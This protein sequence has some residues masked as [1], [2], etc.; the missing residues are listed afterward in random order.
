[1][2]DTAVFRRAAQQ[3]QAIYHICPNMHPDEVTFGHNANAAA[4]TAGVARFVYHSVLRPQSEKMPHHWPKL[5]VEEAL[6]ESGLAVT[7]LQPAAYMQ[8]IAGSWPTIQTEGVYRIPYPVETQLSWVDLADVAET[9]VTILTQP[10]HAGATYE[11]AGPES[12]SPLALAA[13]LSEVSGQA[14]RAEHVDIATWQVQA[15]ADGMNKYA[16]ATLSQMF[17]YYARYH[18]V[19]NANVLQLLL[20]RAPNTFA[21]FAAQLV[22]QA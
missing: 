14:I 19:G 13:I 7:V 6:W 1:M 3:C 12:L 8:N 17:D 16:I 9:A 5:R 10:G 20:G 11:L 18:F 21:A 2:G 22:S 4:Q 15:K